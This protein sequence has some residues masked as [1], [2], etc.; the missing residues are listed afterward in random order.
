MYATSTDGI[1]WPS[2]ARVPI[3]ATTS[4]VDHRI[5]GIGIDTTTSG[6]TAKIGLYYY[7]Y[8]TANCTA[9]SCQLEVGHVSSANGSSTWSGSTTVAG[10]MS[11][12]QIANSTQGR[13]VGD[14]LSTFVIGGKA[15]SVFA[16]GRTPTDGQA[17]DDALYTAGPL[18]VAGG[19][20]A[21]TA[22][23]QPPCPHRRQQQVPDHFRPV[24][25]LSGSAP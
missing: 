21:S 8:P 24:T 18:T 2:V 5:P 13:M 23:G 9:S 10:P 16:V 17:F 22:R 3:D 19:S 6:T 25:D 7:F 12:S 15:V 20:V 4:G 11:L 14:Y 1:S